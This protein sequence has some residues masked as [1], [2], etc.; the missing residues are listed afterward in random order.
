MEM[1]ERTLCFNSQN[2]QLKYNSYFNPW[3]DKR[4]LIFIRNFISI[5]KPS[6]HRSKTGAQST[7]I[8]VTYICFQIGKFSVDLELKSLQQD[9]DISIWKCNNKRKLRLQWNEVPLV[10]N[11]FSVTSQH[12]HPVMYCSVFDL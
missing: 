8:A 7:Y 1:F 6:E 2:Y 4:C 9:A 12:R 10:I 11:K 3:I 5:G